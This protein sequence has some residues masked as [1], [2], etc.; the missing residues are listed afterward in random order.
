MN[1]GTTI[2]V[3]VDHHY[4]VVSLTWTWRRIALLTFV[5]AG[6]G[7]GGRLT[8][9]TVDRVELWRP[10]QTPAEPTAVPLDNYLVRY[11]NP[12]KWLL[13]TPTAP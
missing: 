13:P 6:A 3:N 5:L 11:P 4:R 8:L 2:K 9:D 10:I 1:S 12:D 7:Y